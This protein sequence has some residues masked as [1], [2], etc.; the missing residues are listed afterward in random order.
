MVQ[1]DG[2]SAAVYTFAKKMLIDTH[3]HLYADDF[4]DDRDNVIRKALEAGVKKIVLPNIDSGSIEGMMSLARQYPGTCFPLMGL[5]PTS[6]GE[7]YKEKL[8]AVESWL[9]KEKF[10]GI[11]ET[12]IDLYWDKTWSS[13]QADSFRR[14][15]SIARNM[16]LP[17]VIHVR[18]SFN[19]VYAIVKEEQDGNLR[20]VFHCFS[21]SAEEAKK[22]ADCGFLLGIGGVVT[23]RNSNLST[24][25]PAVDLQNIVLETDS[26]YLAPVPHRGRRNESAYLTKIVDKM[27]EIYRMSNE[28]IARVTTENAEMLFGI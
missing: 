17:V 13:E 1:T 15:I 9:D 14:H 25:L 2:N 8:K 26:P 18:N 16:N 3:A 27:A 5:H 22:V 10:Y 6:V 7:D 11:G 12:G 23:F 21:G 4:N 20:G 19:E 28:E 24:I